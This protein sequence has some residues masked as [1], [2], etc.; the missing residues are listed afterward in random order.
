[1]DQVGLLKTYPYVEAQIFVLGTYHTIEKRLVDIQNIVTME[2]IT[3]G[4]Y[5]IIYTD[6]TTQNIHGDLTTTATTG[7]QLVLRGV[8][9]PKETLLLYQYVHASA[10][11]D[12]LNP[13]GAITVSYEDLTNM[14]TLITITIVDTS[15]GSTAFTDTY[16]DQTFSYTWNTVPNATSYEVTVAIDHATFGSF[17][18]KYYLP[19]EYERA[20][21]P[22]DLAFLGS[23]MGISTAML[24]PALLIIF[25]AGCFSE[26]TAE[27]AAVLTVIIAILLSALGWIE[28]TQAALITALSLA[29]LGGIVTA[30]RRMQV[31]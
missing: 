17:D 16:T 4:R 23:T 13:I 3:G 28:I 24:I 9:F 6:G 1:M 8:D 12:F 20:S 10:I 22:F 18:Y 21:A 26:L 2:L 14:T 25:V 19:G 31:Y 29:V 30:R 11:R 27:V 7:I 5:R 15:D